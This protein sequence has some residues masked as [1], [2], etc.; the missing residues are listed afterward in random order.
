MHVKQFYLYGV[1][2]YFN[3]RF[4]SIAVCVATVNKFAATLSDDVKKDTKK[5]ETEFKKFCKTTKSKENRF[6]S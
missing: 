5:I 1:F 4:L 2:M 6:V 3:E